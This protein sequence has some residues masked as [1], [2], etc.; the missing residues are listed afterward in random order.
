MLYIDHEII[1]LGVV[2]GDGRR[3]PVATP[4]IE[5]AGARVVGL[6]GGSDP[7]EP[8]APAAP[9]FHLVHQGGADSFSLEAAPHHDPVEIKGADRAWGRTPAGPTSED[10][11][12]LRTTKLVIRIGLLT[13]A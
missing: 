2:I 13:D 5:C 12:D 1:S 3:N 11:I 4:F 9:P 6:A 10:A 8:G 7:N